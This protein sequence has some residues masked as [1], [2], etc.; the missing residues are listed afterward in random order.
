MS[1]FQ[2]RPWA[3]RA[4][5]MAGLF[6][7]VV[8]ATSL[9]TAH[10]DS[11]CDAERLCVWTGTNYTGTKTVYDFDDVLDLGCENVDFRSLKIGAGAPSFLVVVTQY[12]ET[13]CN[14]VGDRED[15]FSLLGTP[16]GNPEINNLTAGVFEAHS[17]SFLTIF[18]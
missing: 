3:R 1:W 6:A 15:T 10:A 13:N 17:F 4:A 8:P 14:A 12:R 16:T 11:S 18:F 2:Q 5:V 7:L 9:G